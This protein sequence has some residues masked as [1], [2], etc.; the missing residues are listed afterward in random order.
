MPTTILR[1]TSTQQAS[2]GTITGSTSEHAAMSDNLDTSY[3][4]I[5]ITASIL[6]MTDFTIPAGAV[7]HRA[8][9]RGRGMKTTTTNNSPWLFG[10]DRGPSTAYWESLNVTTLTDAVPADFATPYVTQAFS[11]SEVNAFRFVVGGGSGY[12][13]TGLNAAQTIEAYVDVEYADAPTAP[14][15]AAISS[16]LT[17]RPTVSWTHNGGAGAPSGQSH[18][19]VR[20]FTAAQY[21]IGGFDPLTSPAQWDSGQIASASASAVVATSL[22]NG[23]AHRAYVWTWQTTNSVQQKS[24]ATTNFITFT[25]SVTVPTPTALS[26]SDGS[27]VTTS[28]P[29]MNA[30]VGVMDSGFILTRRVWD[31]ATNNIFTTGLQTISD[32]TY[33]N[34]SSAA[35]AFPTGRL[36]QGTWYLRCRA[37]DSNGVFSAATATATITVAHVPTTTSRTPSGGA[38]ALYGSTVQVNWTFSDVDVLDVQTKYQ[39]QLW[40]LSAPGTPIDSTLL[41]SASGFHVFTVPDATWKDV[42]LR[43]K[44]LVH[45]FDNVSSGYSAETAIFLSDVPTVAITAPLNN[46]VIT[47]S[48]PLITWTFTASRS[49]TQSQFKVDI[50]NVTSGL[51]VLSSGWIVGNA[52]LWQVPTPSIAVGPTYS[53]TV[54]TLDSVGLTGSSVNNFTATYAAPTTPTFSLNSTLYP[55]EGHYDLDWSGATV[56]GNFRAWRVYRRITGTPTWVLQAEYATVTTRTYKDYI[57]ASGIN[58]DY[59]VVQVTTSFGVA[60]ESVYPILSVANLTTF[61]YFLVCPADP[62]LNLTLFSV[63]GESFSEE[64]E[65]ATLNIIGK[66]RRV[67]YGERLGKIGTLEVGFRNRDGGLTGRAQRLKMEALRDSVHDVYLTNPFGDVGLV[68]LMASSV[69]RVAGTGLNEMVNASISYVEVAS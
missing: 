63:T 66:G 25:P 26:P 24:P 12:S 14:T 69:N 36:P 5:T 9:A 23:S 31:W 10:F 65:A 37:Q 22:V 39:V 1:P 50:L 15:V 45:D 60:V 54:S 48:S 6:N 55:S 27:T 44:V 16:T 29:A 61:W 68:A 3:V 62:T 49:R 7:V 64:W 51:S 67:E 47:T 40:K 21:G 34:G 59:A 20:V 11:Q 46:A 2:G 18:Y 43:W 4:S 28:T 58:Y 56:D 41:T 53:V 57:A 52:L 32:P 35:Y 42:E 8:R 38:T 13:G 30:T 33:S 19:Q 17:A